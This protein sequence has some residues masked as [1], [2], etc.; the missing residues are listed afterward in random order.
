MDNQRRRRTEQTWEKPPENWNKLNVDASFLSDQN[1]GAW[2]AVLRDH[3]GNV[4]LSVWGCIP[5]CQ[6]AEAGEA[7]ACREGVNAILHISH[8]PVIL[9]CDNVAVVNELQSRQRSK[10]AISMIIS[11]VKARISSLPDFKISKV[12]RLGNFAA[13]SLAGLGL[14]EWNH[15]VLMN[16]VPECAVG[17]IQKDCNPPCNTLLIE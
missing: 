9:E 13:H 17:T 8:N 16:A 12:N 1:K 14:R 10:S 15:G 11:D 7:I 2:G 3:N 5:H 4:L 6:S